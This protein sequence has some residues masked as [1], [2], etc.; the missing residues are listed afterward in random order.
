[1]SEAL[2]YDKVKE[3]LAVWDNRIKTFEGM[4]E[5]QNTIFDKIESW[6]DEA[7]RLCR[8]KV[9]HFEGCMRQVNLC[10]TQLM[11]SIINNHQ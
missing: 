2:T 1:M 7:R 10:K 6:D 11:Q 4:I 9:L 8:R 5:E 3:L